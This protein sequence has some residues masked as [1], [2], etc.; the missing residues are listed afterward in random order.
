MKGGERVDLFSMQPDQAQ[1]PL[2]ERM[3]PRT[4]DE[5]VGQ[6]Q[7]IGKGKLLRRAIESDQISSLILYGP[8]GTGKTTLAKVIAN[9]SSARFESLNAVSAGVSDIRKLVEEAKTA[10]DLYQIKTIVFI[11]E[12]HRF[13]KSQQD[14]LLPYVE[15]GLLTLIGA[16]TENPFFEVNAAL[17][18]RSLIFQVQPLSKEDLKRLARQA[19][20][21][22][23]RGL[24]ALSPVVH[25]DALEHLVQYADGD[26][27]RLLNALELAAKSS[28]LDADGRLVIDLATAEECIQRRT[29]R[30]DKQGDQHYDTISAFIKSIRGSDPDAALLWMARMLE[31]GEDPKFIC[32]RMI[33]LA[34]E[35]IGNADPRALQI[36]IAAFQAYE[37]L[38]LPEAKLAMAQA[39]TYLAT[40]P[41]SNASYVAITRAQ[42]A[43]RQHGESL[44]V[45]V[46]LRDA[47]YP[48]ARRLG[49]GEGYRYP[50]DYPG[51][52]VQQ[53]YMPDS[54][55]AYGPFYVPTDHGYERVIAERLRQWKEA[56]PDTQRTPDHSGA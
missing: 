25:D 48:G 54:Y 23:E 52:Y 12:I 56:K 27:R 15:Q 16:T 33:I 51:G 32:R 34:S 19:L 22:A 46:H 28:S 4:L 35:D 17:L 38:G 1:A 31:A 6:E 5:M 18:S 29:V 20:T 45:P 44:Q 7:L 11:D 14:A 21:D 50:H 53:S 47:H 37:I 41:K 40:A 26:A 9:H 30:Y 43:L 13:N 8:P 3:R 55:K 24:G 42:E 2:A 39:V 36:A 49:H 10:R